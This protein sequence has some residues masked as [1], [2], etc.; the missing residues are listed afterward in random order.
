M[1][2]DFDKC[3]NL[4]KRN[5][6]LILKVLSDL[7][8]WRG[9]SNKKTLYSTRSCVNWPTRAKKKTRQ[10]NYYIFTYWSFF[11]RIFFYIFLTPN[12][13]LRSWDNR[14]LKRKSEWKCF[15]AVKTLQF[16]E[17]RTI[18]VLIRTVFTVFH[19]SNSF[20]VLRYQ[21]MC[22]HMSGYIF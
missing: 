6:K 22:K 3:H 20:F 9:S 7:E 5:F 16:F 12:L 19:S 1:W 13:R 14:E 2:T 17:K 10:I 18:A 21:W 15:C 11:N 8:P 4:S